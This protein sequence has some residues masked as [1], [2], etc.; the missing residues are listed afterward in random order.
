MAYLC[1]SFRQDVQ[2]GPIE[3]WLWPT[4]LR[5]PQ[6][7][8]DEAQSMIGTTSSSPGPDIPDMYLPYVPF[9]QL[10]SDD[11]PPED[12]SDKTYSRECIALRGAWHRLACM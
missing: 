1:Q 3:A 6:C 8:Q 2:K 10:G 7:I 9:S 5:Q 4:S 11:L 12:D